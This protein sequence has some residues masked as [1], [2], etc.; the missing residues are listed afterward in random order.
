[1]NFFSD[2]SSAAGCSHGRATEFFTESVTSKC[3]FIAYTCYSEVITV[4][5]D[6]FLEMY[7]GGGNLSFTI[8]FW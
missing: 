6:Q 8:Y 5:L 7:L 2:P 4:N 1:M 3:P